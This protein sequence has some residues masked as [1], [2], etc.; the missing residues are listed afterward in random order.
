[1]C[2][3]RI[4][5]QFPI[6]CYKSE[7][8]E[9]WTLFKLDCSRIIPRIRAVVFTIVRMYA[10]RVGSVSGGHPDPVQV[11]LSWPLWWVL[12]KM[13]SSA[14]NV[15]N[16]VRVKGSRVTE[17]YR[18]ERRCWYGLN[19]HIQRELWRPEIGN[20]AQWGLMAYC[21][22]YRLVACWRSGGVCHGAFWTDHRIG[23]RCMK[24]LS[25]VRDILVSNTCSKSIKQLHIQVWL[26][27]L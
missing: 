27:D 12:W 5:L 16:S 18:T 21:R 14:T 1:M 7:I 6:N 4:K 24:P 26:F 9:H 13:Q 23:G 22:L 2:Y 10:R 25:E 8:N 11:P 20:R 15:E 3:I 17:D 19:Q